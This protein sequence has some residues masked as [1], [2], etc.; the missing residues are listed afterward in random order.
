[1][2][3]NN[4][5]EPQASNPISGITSLSMVMLP[6]AFLIIALCVGI[7][8]HFIPVSYTTLTPPMIYSV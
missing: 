3:D 7:G 2:T 6:V 4:M 5:Q 1:M 8:R